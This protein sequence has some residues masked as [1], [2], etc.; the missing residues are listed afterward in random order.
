[1]S[2]SEPIRI[3]QLSAN[4]LTLME[5]LLATF[6]EAFDDVETCNS[7]RPSNAYLKRSLSR[8]YF[9]RDRSVKKWISHQR[10]DRLPEAHT[11]TVE[12]GGSV[13]TAYNTST[14]NA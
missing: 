1:M 8:D 10:S 3:R 4:D 12:A 2:S 9:H 5:G 11:R 7:S 14:S 13:A 6:G